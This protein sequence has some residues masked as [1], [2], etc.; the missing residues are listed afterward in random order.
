MDSQEV[1]VACATIVLRNR[2]ETRGFERDHNTKA[3]RRVK[4]YVYRKETLLGKA[5][6]HLGP[7]EDVAGRGGQVADV[8][9]ARQE[10]MLISALGLVHKRRGDPR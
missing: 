5:T 4:R 7:I 1:I 8:D 6:L 9:F 10:R 3:S 2:L